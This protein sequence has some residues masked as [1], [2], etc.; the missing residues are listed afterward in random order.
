MWVVDFLRFGTNGLPETSVINYQHILCNNPEERRPPHY[1]GRSLKSRLKPCP[2]ERRQ[3]NV[4][5][6]LPKSRIDYVSVQ[7]TKLALRRVLHETLRSLNWWRNSSPLTE[8][9][10][11][12]NLTLSQ[13]NS[14][15]HS[16][17]ILGAFANLR[18][19]P[20]RV[21]MSVCL[22]VRMEQFGSHGK[23]LHDIWYIFRKCVEKI[24]VS[25]KS[26]GVLYEAQYTFLP[27]FAQFLKREIFRQEL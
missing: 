13:V 25:L 20:I 2:Y 10:I 5:R 19:A 17:F 14:H 18:K 1:R 24:H 8:H 26:A 3:F 15:S 22:S 27:H 12:R 16:S 11:S 23:N 21:V 7:V 4:S 9:E 6:S